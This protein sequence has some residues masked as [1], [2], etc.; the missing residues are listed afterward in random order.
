M[1]P[2]L[3]QV[4]EAGRTEP[5]QWEGQAGGEEGGSPE[6]LKVHSEKEGVRRDGRVSGREGLGEL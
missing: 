3:L 5:E 2:G 4:R 1:G 6:L